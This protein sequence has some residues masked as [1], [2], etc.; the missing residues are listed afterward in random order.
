VCMTLRM[1]LWSGSGVWVSVARNLVSVGCG[2]QQRTRCSQFP[3]VRWSPTAEASQQERAPRHVCTCVSSMLK[4]R[5]AKCLRVNRSPSAPGGQLCTPTKGLSTPFCF[6]CCPAPL[7][8]ARIW[9]DSRTSLHPLPS[10]RAHVCCLVLYVLFCHDS[11]T[12]A[13][14]SLKRGEAN[15]H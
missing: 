1:L 8:C 14:P 15:N 4:V 5:S 7:S 11:P 2:R 10:T 3:W 13:L 6:C 12:C 9:S